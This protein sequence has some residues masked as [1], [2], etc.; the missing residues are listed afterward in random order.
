[1]NYVCVKISGLNLIRIVDRLVEKNVYISNLVVKTKYIK[2]TIDENKLIL[3]DKICKKEHKFYQIIYKNG[4]KSLFYK[5]PYMLGAVIASIIIATYFVSISLFI[6]NVDV[7]Y[8]S[9]IDYDLTEVNTLLKNNG[10]VSGMNKNKFSLSEIQKL[11]M[12]EIES[13]EGCEVRLN[14][15]NLN[16]CIYPATLKYEVG[17]E[18]L[19]SKFD[20]IIIF[21]EAYSGVL[22]VKV[23]DT[24]SKGDILI[25]NNSGATGKIL[26]KTYVTT[27]KI[28]NENR[29]EIKYT[30]NI[31][32]IKDFL[33]YP[34]FWIYGKNKCS[35]SKF[36]VEKRS[37]YVNKNLF[38]PILCIENIYREIEIEEKN[39]PFE[40]VKE[41]IK[42]ELLLE[43]KQKVSGNSEIS[44]VTYSIVTEG[45]Y[46][47][48]DCF[49][50]TIV[51]LV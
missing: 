38:L 42:D 48:I 39:V 17:T 51:E 36:V 43:A 47:R 25:E 6:R 12:L 28:F 8:K 35:F 26:A 18:N 15:N 33:I 27:T 20:G 11:I 34:N 31:Y 16:I 3:L 37:F 23:G 9:N 13:V 1:M 45:S 14:G 40:S 22:K 4:F 7:T 24:I 50:E 49:V 46:T 32:T 29:Q 19:Y 30:G 10:I 41:N 44:N 5:I 21:A 2:F